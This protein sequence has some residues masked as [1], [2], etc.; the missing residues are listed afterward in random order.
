MLVEGKGEYRTVWMQGNSVWM[1][2]QLLLPFS[3][4]LLEAPTFLDTRR[5]I[6]EMN[7]RGAGAIGATAGYGMAQGFIEGEPDEAKKAL[8]SARPTAKNLTYATDR[9]YEAAIG[10]GSPVATA[11]KEAQDIADEDSDGCF[12]IGKYGAELIYQKSRE[13]GRRVNMLTHCNAGWLAFVDWGSALSPV[14]VA[15]RNETPVHVYA[16]ETRPRSQGARLTAWELRN[17]G[18][19][20]QVIPDTAVAIM[21]ERGMIDLVIVG[22]DRIAANGDTANKLGTQSVARNARH[23]GVDFYFAAPLSTI[24]R[25]CPNGEVIEIEQR[26][27]DEVLYMQ[28]LTDDNEVTRVRVISPD[29]PAYNPASFDVTKAV[30]VT[31]LIT[32]KGIIKPNPATIAGLFR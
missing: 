13:L 27:E 17:E 4:E 31:G 16:D 21:M 22:A 26:D 19:S 18:V 2:D 3:F 12:K 32:P 24:D 23:Y 7:I 10:T 1:I 28:G 14:Y 25:D 8:D 29:S 6:K 5:T 15:K 11:L 20:H 9:V 30:D